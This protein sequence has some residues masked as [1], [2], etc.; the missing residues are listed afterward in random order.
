METDDDQKRSRSKKSLVSEA[1]S[2]TS[3]TEDES[4][5]R[6]SCS[7]SNDLTQYINK[8]EVLKLYHNNELMCLGVVDFNVQLVLVLCHK[9]R[10][11]NIFIVG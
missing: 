11:V 2:A 4:I 6:V 7:F 5:P 3:A 8:K 10:I 9:V 1:E